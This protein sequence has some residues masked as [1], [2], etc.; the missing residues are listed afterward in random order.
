MRRFKV[1]FDPVMERDVRDTILEKRVGACEERA[2][3]LELVLR[4]AGSESNNSTRPHGGQAKPSGG[5][6][7]RT[8]YLPV[9]HLPPP[10][11][12]D[13]H[14]YSS[15][16]GRLLSFRERNRLVF[17]CSPLAST[18][19]P[20]SRCAHHTRRDRSPPLQPAGLPTGR[21]RSPSPARPSP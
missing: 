3:W 2:R 1:L 9:C 21:R 4:A 5:G 10:D 16:Q 11:S 17:A 8:S 7:R 13:F 18:S 20:R 19:P 12:A 15:S 6:G 14:L